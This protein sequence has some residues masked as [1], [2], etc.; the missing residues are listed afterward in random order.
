M[1]NY[2][3]SSGGSDKYAASSEYRIALGFC[4]GLESETITDT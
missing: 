3:S 1:F 4:L 2:V